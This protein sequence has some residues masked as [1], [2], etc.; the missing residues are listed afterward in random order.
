M[1]KN[2]PC[3]MKNSL[4][5][6]FRFAT[7]ITKNFPSKT[8]T[9]QSVRQTSDLKRVTSHCWCMFY[10]CLIPSH[11]RMVPFVI[12]LTEGLCVILK[13]FS[14]PC[15]LSD[16]ISTFGRSVPELSMIS[17]EV[18]EWMYNVHGHRITEWNHFIMSPNLLQTYS[19]AIHDKGAALENCFGFVDGT[20]RPISKPGVNQR[21]VYNGHKR[22]HALK[23]QS[24]A[25]PNGLIGHLFG[26]VEGRMHDARM[27]DT[28]GLYVD[29]AQFAFSPAG[30]EMCIYGDPAY[31]LR[32]QL[33]CPFRNGVLTRQMEEFNASMSSVRTS[34]EWL[35]GDLINYFKF[36]DYKKNLKIGLS[37]VGKMYIVCALLRNALTCLYRNTTADYFGL[38][39]PSLVDYFS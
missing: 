35:F 21:A 17:N 9:Q 13:R 18:T 20:V 4:H 26:P 32:T 28:S 27:L 34:V 39:P 33:Q 12:Q 5:K 8:K 11:V 25:L 15:R 24:L 10:R 36:L 37:H 19:E 31:P 16:M 30:Q 2:L 38:D 7:G 22:V 14:Y 1:T 29:L 3:C 6:T 23:F